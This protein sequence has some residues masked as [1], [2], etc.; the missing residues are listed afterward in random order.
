MGHLQRNQKFLETLKFPAAA[1]NATGAAGLSD[2]WALRS[3]SELD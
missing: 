2:E 3:Y 1:L